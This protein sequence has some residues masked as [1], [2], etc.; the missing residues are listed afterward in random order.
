MYPMYK[1]PPDYKNMEQQG[2][3]KNAQ[4][5]VGALRKPNIRKKI[6]TYAW[7]FGCNE[8]EIQEK[9]Q[10][11][12]MFAAHFAT[13]PKRQQL[14]EK[15]A[16]AWLLEIPEIK[17]FE[18][19]PSSKK[20][21]L[22]VTNDGII[23]EGK[24]KAPGKSLDFRWITKGK[25]CF[26]SHKYTDQKGGSQDQ[27]FEEMEYLLKRFRDCEEK[28]YVLIVIVDGAYYTDE[29]MQK[30]R[31]LTRNDELRSFVAHIEQVPGIL[32]ELSNE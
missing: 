2:W 10:N 31:R 20:K 4:S 30:L 11:D 14:H 1:E 15:V 32:A 8:E 5:V 24:G 19:L 7:R 26:A 16:A 29:K 17:E 28:N 23:Q 12:K 18:I 27:Q 6:A 9:I 25:T 22:Y 3:R 21:G 13:D